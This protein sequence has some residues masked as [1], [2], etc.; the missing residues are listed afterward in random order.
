MSQTSKFIFLVAMGLLLFSC[1][2]K[3]VEAIVSEQGEVA[4]LELV[5]SVDSLSNIEFESFYAKIAT[6]YSDS[7]QNISFKT[8][9]WMITDSASNFLI[10]Y[11][12]IPVFG[13][14]VTVD[15]VHISNK[16]EKCYK[17][18]SLAFLQEQFGV[19]FSLD[20]LQDLI[21]G[22]PTNF[23][24]TRTYYKVDAVEGF[25]L[26]THGKQDI[27]RIKNGELDEIVMY[28]TLSP[29]LTQLLSTT[30]VSYKD[31]TEVNVVYKSRETIENYSV[32]S[33]VEIRIISPTKSI[34]ID[35][36]YSKSRVNQSEPIQFI[37]SESYE[38]CK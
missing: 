20:N 9:A 27:E 10:T 34:K 25:S 31:A 7:A 5:A 29:D 22:I 15:S 6:S 2:E 17:H 13:A 38:E 3:N 30:V 12:S 32:P 23:D 16:R 33:Q 1:S 37:I 26:C 21:L 18:T 28:Y 35:M 36:S 4:K 8:S 11:A 19:E 14:L 24:S